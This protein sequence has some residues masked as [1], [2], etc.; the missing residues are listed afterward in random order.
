MA[1][2][3]ND[4]PSAERNSAKFWRWVRAMLRKLINRKTFF[5]AVSVIL[6]VDRILR[7]IKRLLGDI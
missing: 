3:A 6:W 5:F 2:E 7:T 1:I 4:P